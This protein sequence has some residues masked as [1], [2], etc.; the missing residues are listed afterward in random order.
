MWKKCIENSVHLKI[1]GVCCT[2]A[3]VYVLQF[4]V[5]AEIISLDAFNRSET[6]GVVAIAFMKV[7][8]K[9]VNMLSVT[10][11]YAHKSFIIIIIIIK[12]FV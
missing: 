11:H 9:Y 12:I 7:T 4:V 2:D 1:T 6:V 10:V 3:Q 8:I 5:D